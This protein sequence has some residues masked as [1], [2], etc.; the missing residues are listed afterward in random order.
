MVSGADLESAGGHPTSPAFVKLHSLWTETSKVE[1]PQAEL[2]GNELRHY[3]TGTVLNLLHEV[4]EMDHLSEEKSNR[5][6]AEH[7]R[8]VRPYLMGQLRLLSE[9]GTLLWPTDRVGCS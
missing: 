7:F 6:L 5:E 9:I 3:F 1:V 2:T 4:S 8:D